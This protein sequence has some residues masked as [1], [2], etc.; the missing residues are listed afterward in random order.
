M[1]NIALHHVPQTIEDSPSEH[2]KIWADYNAYIDF[3]KQN[4]KDVFEKG[5][6]IFSNKFLRFKYLEFIKAVPVSLYQVFG[7]RHCKSFFDEFG[8]LFY[9][10]ETN[11]VRPVLFHHPI[12]GNVFTSYVKSYWESVVKHPLFAIDND[13]LVCNFYQYENTQHK[14]GNTSIVT[15]GE[16]DIDWLGV[17]TDK[18]S[19]KAGP[20]VYKHFS[21][22]MLPIYVASG[23]K[24]TTTVMEMLK[25]PQCVNALSLLSEFTSNDIL[26]T[27]SLLVDCDFDTGIVRQSLEWLHEIAK[28]CE[29]S[30]KSF[31]DAIIV[32]MIYQR[33]IN[34]LYHSY[35]LIRELLSCSKNGDDIKEYARK[36]VLGDGATEEPISTELIQQTDEFI[37]KN[38]YESAFKRRHALLK[39]VPLIWQPTT[40][41]SSNAFY[42]INVK[43]TSI[44]MGELVTMLPDIDDISFKMDNNL[45]AFMG[46]TTASDVDSKPILI[47]DTDKRNPISMY[48]YSSL[49][50]AKQMSMVVD[51]WYKVSGI[52]LPPHLL[53]TETYDEMVKKYGTGYILLIDGCKD[54]AEEVCLS[55]FSE[56]LKPVFKPYERVIDRF[57]LVN[58]LDKNDDDVRECQGLIVS[59]GMRVPKMH[60]IVNFKDSTTVMYV[61]DR[62]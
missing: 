46:L 9:I 12:L 26:K 19:V 41:S 55:L 1:S 27:L 36:L 8:S 30:P 34:E 29:S 28:T 57:S 33:S 22:E 10:D 49:T 16:A 6:P 59:Q 40:R 21:V 20:Y 48:C 60:L 15:T 25:K 37:M 11:T 17:Q 31:K 5:Y 54:A 24:V 47:W 43:P 42:D 51:R 44:S 2:A 3:V 39:D 53:N 13:T 23:D 18:N 58:L 45:Y 61:V 4:V 7:C 56:T 32:R 35:G 52:T 14:W 62:F 38:G 50:G